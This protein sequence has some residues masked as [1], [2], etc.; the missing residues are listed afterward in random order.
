MEELE[1]VRGERVGTPDDAPAKQS[2][3]GHLH[4]KKASDVLQRKRLE[5]TWLKI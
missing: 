2:K 4:F 3:P 5:K 1:G